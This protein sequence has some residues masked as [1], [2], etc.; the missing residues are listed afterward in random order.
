MCLKKH[1][2][3]HL[4]TRAYAHTDSYDGRTLST[5]LSAW[6]LKEKAGPQVQ[7]PLEKLG[8]MSVQEA[9]EEE[10]NFR[11]RNNAYLVDDSDEKKK[12]AGTQ[13][14]LPQEVGDSFVFGAHVTIKTFNKS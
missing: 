8:C 9:M 4:R 3:T 14:R 11:I 6:S 7:D 2:H 12:E 1:T 5:S 10:V 13:K